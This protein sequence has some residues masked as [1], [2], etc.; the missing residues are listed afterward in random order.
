M[1]AM[2]LSREDWPQVKLTEEQVISI[3]VLRAA[4]ASLAQ[5][6]SDFGISDGQVGKIVNGR[7]WVDVGGPLSRGHQVTREPD[8]WFTAA[9]LGL[10]WEA[11]KLRTR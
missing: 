3:R 7:A 10:S 9:S 2:T 1:T 11:A 8:P 6:A 5:L 4:G